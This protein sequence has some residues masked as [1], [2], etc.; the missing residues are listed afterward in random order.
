L[1]TGGGKSLIYQLASLFLPCPVV[2][3]TPLIA[4]AEDQ[5]DKLEAWRVA[6]TRLDS[7]LCS[8]EARE[9]QAAIATG[10]L[11]LVYVTPERLQNPAF[12]ALLRPHGCSLFVVDEAHSVSQWGHD[13]RPAYADLTCAAQALGRPPILA[14]TATATTEVERDI[15]LSDMS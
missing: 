6:A 8:A 12:M 11:D 5:T 13:F 4:L 1:P 9:A 7:S 10:K 2:V 14:L 15:L 3:V